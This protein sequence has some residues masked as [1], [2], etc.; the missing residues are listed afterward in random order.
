MPQK[1]KKTEHYQRVFLYVGI[2]ETIRV[3]MYITKNGKITATGAKNHMIH[4]ARLHALHFLLSVKVNGGPCTCREKIG[5]QPI[6]KNFSLD[7]IR[8]PQRKVFFLR[9][10][11]FFSA[12]PPTERVS[13]CPFCV[14]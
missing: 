10:A 5:P 4:I 3:F 1:E 6:F 13:V 14:L 8:A 7:Q 12:R 11:Q 9:A 2:H